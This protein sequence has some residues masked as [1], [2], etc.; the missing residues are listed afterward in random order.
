MLDK[1]NKEIKA[2]DFVK[3]IGV[4]NYADGPKEKISKN[5]WIIEEDGRLPE[6]SDDMSYL[7]IGN[8]EEGILP[9]FIPFMQGMLKIDVGSVPVNYRV[10]KDIE[11]KN[12]KRG[13]IVRITG[14]V[15]LETLKNGFLEKVSDDMAHQHVMIVV[16]TIKLGLSVKETQ[17]G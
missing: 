13:D 9:E 7:V 15:S 12:W 3:K 8:K 4:V 10:L 16:D 11:S 14:N 6:I 2:G 1:N 17:N 5:T